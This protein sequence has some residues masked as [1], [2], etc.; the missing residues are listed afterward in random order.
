MTA[1]DDRPDTGLP[2]EP[3]D[4]GPAQPQHVDSELHVLGAA[5]N[6]GRVDTDRA[7][8]LV[9]QL[10][11][12]LDPADFWRPAHGLVWQAMLDATEGSDPLD[13]A[14][15]ATRVLATGHPGARAIA[16]ELP[17]IMGDAAPAASATWHARL[18]AEAAQR[19]RVAAIGLNLAQRAHADGYDPA[20]DIP[21]GIQALEHAAGLGRAQAGPAP[22][23][24]LLEQAVDLIEHPDNTEL[25]PSGLDDLDML[26]PGMR[27]GQLIVVGARPSIGKSVFGLT[28]AC[29]AAVRLRMPTLVFSLEMTRLEW[30]ARLLAARCRVDLGKILAGTCDETDWS[31]IARQMPEIAEAPLTIDDSSDLTM[32]DIRARVRA[33]AR[34]GLRLVVVDYLQLIRLGKAESRQTGVDEIARQLKVLAGDVGVPVVVLCQL[35]RGPEMRADKRPAMADL[36]ESGGLE[37]HPDVVI[38]LHRPDFYDP[39]QKPGECELIVAKHRNGRTGTAQVAFQGHY[40]RM[41]SLAMW[42]G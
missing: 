28:L 26:Y 22:I 8:A 24:A 19:R 37:N 10:A 32:A 17:R 14:A 2:P 40:S 9:D 6:L 30:T 12:I 39:E 11:P 27:P 41:S 4:E 3:P 34:H 42:A 31:R 33:Q 20:V 23:A 21:A 13:P 29:E 15:V 7:H 36:R 16:A 38:L 25:I 5:L 18:V 35:N 1:V